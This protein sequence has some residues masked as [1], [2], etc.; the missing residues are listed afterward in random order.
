MDALAEMTLTILNNFKNG[1]RMNFKMNEEN[2]I[3]EIEILQPLEN[4]PKTTYL[5]EV[6]YFR[7]MV[8]II[9]DY[10]EHLQSTSQHSSQTTSQ[11]YHSDDVIDVSSDDT[12]G[13]SSDDDQPNDPDATTSQVFHIDDVIDVSSDDTDDESSD[14]D[15]PNDPDELLKTLMAL[16]HV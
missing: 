15:Q 1:N 5:I 6:N 3:V 13:E 7:D 16:Y 12:D 11:A 14:Y 8:S 2:G 4:A 9:K 10:L